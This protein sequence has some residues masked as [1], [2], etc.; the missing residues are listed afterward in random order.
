M[1]D[2][3]AIKWI[4]DVF[5]DCIITARDKWSFA[6]GLISTVIFLVSS[7]PQIILNFKEKKV[8]GQSPFFFSLLFCG[9]A[10]NLIGVFITH[11]LITQIIQGV[12]YCALDGIL[13][14]QF[15]V[16]KYIIKSNGDDN[17]DDD[18]EMSY[19][20]SQNSQIETDDIN[21]SGNPSTGALATTALVGTAS[22]TDWA[23]PY[24][25]DQVV[26]SIFGWIATVIFT[27]SRVPQIVQN[28]KQQAVDNLSPFYFVLSISGNFTYSF[29]VFLR[30]LES[31]Y[32]WK[33]APFIAG[34]LGPLA[35]DFI[36]LFQMLYYKRKNKR[37]LS[38]SDIQKENSNE[39]EVDHVQ[40]L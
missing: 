35:C 39:E 30:S 13:F 28:V 4:E 3:G 36:V 16:Y 10:S 23:R 1:C 17:D 29:S 9:S 40:E 21:D 19:D 34:S 15:I 37:T 31:N 5:D 12:C 38:N 22:A 20:S 27:V 11:G 33:Q 25:K 32:L 6:I 24:K 2:E 8:D 7:L 18:R 26:G 14:G